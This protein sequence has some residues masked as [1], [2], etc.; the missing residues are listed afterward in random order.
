VTTM[1]ELTVSLAHEVNQADC[2]A[3]TNANTCMLWLDGATPN[4]EEARAAAMRIVQDGTRASDIISRIRLLFKKGTPER[5]SVDV[6]DLIREMIVLLRSE[7]VR[8]DISVRRI[9]PPICPR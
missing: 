9:W 1:G 5:S 8:Y 3:L 4:V 2:A 7:A 6:N